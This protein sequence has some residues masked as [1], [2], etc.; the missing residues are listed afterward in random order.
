MLRPGPSVARKRTGSK[1]IFLTSVIETT[2]FLL[3]SVQGQLSSWL[4]SGRRWKRLPRLTRKIE[5]KASIP[6]ATGWSLSD[7]DQWLHRRE[8]GYLRGTRMRSTYA[9]AA[10]VGCGLAPAIRL[11]L[12]RPLHGAHAGD[13]AQAQ[14]HA[15]EVAHV[16]G[17]GNQI[18]RSEEHTS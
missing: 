1:D 9:L 5:H 3:R 16:F 10:W 15:V 13:A 8:K 18:D 4:A 6:P 17:F 7:L 14:D 12:L 2:S 11:Q